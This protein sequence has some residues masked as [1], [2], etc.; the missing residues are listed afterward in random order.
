[1]W[2]K[3]SNEEKAHWNYDVGAWA[4][5][6]VTQHPGAFM[7]S[8]YNTLCTYMKEISDE[9]GMQ[10][11]STLDKKS[12][13]KVVDKGARALA[14]IISHKLFNDDV[15]ENTYLATI[16]Q[17]FVFYYG[18][19]L[20]YDFTPIP[21]LEQALD[22][23]NEK[24]EL[25]VRLQEKR[26]LTEQQIKMLNRIEAT[27]DTN[28]ATYNKD[29]YDK[30]MQPIVTRYE[31]RPEN[32][33]YSYPHYIPKKFFVTIDDILPNLKKKYWHGP[34]G[35]PLTNEKSLQ[36]LLNMAEVLENISN[37]TEEPDEAM[38]A[39]FSNIKDSTYRKAVN[40]AI[41]N[42]SAADIQQMAAENTAVE[43][44]Q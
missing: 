44:S 14:Y 42:A 24:D 6:Y 30:I 41:Q 43:N 1:M 2:L 12:W 17:S 23:L 11:Q 10:E 22:Q 19:Q 37:Q 28:Y 27:G 26:K 13:R 40:N 21:V 33:R 38:N 15:I 35:T 20:S 34:K 8:L 16:Q 31:S 32:K 5:D 9:M 18:D 25:N 29:V 7:Q 3:L 4:D 36:E 39:Y